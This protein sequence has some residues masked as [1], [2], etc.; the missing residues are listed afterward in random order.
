MYNHQ[1]YIGLMNKDLTPEISL[2]DR[3]ATN[4]LGARLNSIFD[5]INNAQINNA[6]NQP[7]RD[8][9]EIWDCCCDHGYLGIKILA[10]QLCSKMNFVDHKAHIIDHL[11]RRFERYA[12]EKFEGAYQA[13]AQDVGT[14]TFTKEQRHL[15][16]IAGVGGEQTINMM[17]SICE[18]SSLSN[19]DFILCPTTTQFDLREYLVSQKFYVK[20][21]SLVTEKDR[22]Y[23]IL[24][25]TKCASTL[26][27]LSLTGEMW[28]S[29]NPYHKRYLE[30][31]IR[32][33][34]RQTLGG[35]TSSKTRAEQIAKRYQACLS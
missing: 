13:L 20:H 4:T 19:I 3:L 26:K 30:K 24:H 8:Y 29:Q 6:Q 11:K 12:I 21:E 17:S 16:I 7:T 22:D 5:L 10:N 14:L 23:E 27:P 34:Q 35:D 28:Q 32:H 9:D 31:L 15:L 18:N 33:Y 25:V 2:L 1:F